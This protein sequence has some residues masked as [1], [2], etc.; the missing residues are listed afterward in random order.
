MASAYL[1]REKGVEKMVREYRWKL[2]VRSYEGDAWGQ[3][4]ASG[5]LRYFEQ[6]AIDAAADVG[7]GS[8]FHRERGT[9]WVIRRMV[10]LMHNPIRQG[11][12]LEITTW[13]SHFARVRGG[14]EY[15]AMNAR[16]GEM[17]ASGLAE[18]VY[19]DRQKMTPIALPRDLTDDFAAPGAPIGSYDPPAVSD[20]STQPEM[21]VERAVEWHEID[22]MGHVNNAIYADW[23]DDAM[24]AAMGELGWTVSDLRERN[25][26][27]R[28]EHYSLDY[29]RGALPED[30]VAITTRIEGVSDRLGAVRQSITCDDTE[31]LSARSVYG[32]RT[33]TGAP[34]AGPDGWEGHFLTR[35]GEA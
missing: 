24:R 31:V 20:L 2:K 34:V 29:R 35:S 30:Q 17:V 1:M 33:N 11:E 19:L 32:W 7:Y 22:S 6:S 23:L 28:G 4:P 9:A 3:V 5:I 21:R 8:Q 25:L 16:T 10:L 27:L 26:Q 15:R 18:W 13:I 14:R 12:E